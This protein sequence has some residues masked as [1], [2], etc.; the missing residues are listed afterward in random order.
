[1]VDFKPATER[2]GKKIQKKG[3]EHNVDNFLK[4]ILSPELYKCNVLLMIVF[5]CM[6]QLCGSL[7]TNVDQFVMHFKA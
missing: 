4:T 7:S 5:E 2:E 3:C 1:M 6:L